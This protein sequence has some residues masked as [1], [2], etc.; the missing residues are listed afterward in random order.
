MLEKV[1]DEDHLH[2]ERIRINEMDK[3]EATYINKSVYILNIEKLEERVNITIVVSQA[4][5]KYK[6]DYCFNQ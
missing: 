5:W 6:K 4:S 3:L 1:V 2:V